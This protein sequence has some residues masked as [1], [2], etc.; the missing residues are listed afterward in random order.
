[1]IKWLI[2][3]TVLVS[4][5]ILGYMYYEM[6]K[7][8]SGGPRAIV[9][10][11]P[12]AIRIVDGW[13]DGIHRLSGTI[14]LPHSCY[15]VKTD[16][17]IDRNDPSKVT[18][19]IT[20]KDNILDQPICAKIRTRYPFE[21]IVETQKEITIFLSVDGASIPVIVSQTDWQNPSGNIINTDA[22]L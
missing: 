8:S 19:A 11:D 9:I 14:K 1:M 15:S 18:L 7:I 21:T 4:G 5:S 22:A 17:S 12:N 13:K 16:S 3:F 2:L 6:N 10:Q 20:S